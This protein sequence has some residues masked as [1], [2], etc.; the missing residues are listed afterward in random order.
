M[1][2]LGLVK[3][4][5]VLGYDF[6]D[7]ETHQLLVCFNDERTQVTGMQIGLKEEPDEDDSFTS[8]KVIMLDSLG[9]TQNCDYVTLTP[10]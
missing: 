6:G 9:I 2:N 10:E 7:I 1:S 5:T 8:A 3:E 4:L